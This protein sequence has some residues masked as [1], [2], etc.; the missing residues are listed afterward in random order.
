MAKAFE[1]IRHGI[2]AIVYA[3][4]D[5]SEQL[6]REL[7]RRQV[8]LCLASGVHGM[9]ALGLATEVGKLTERERM[10]VMDWAAEDTDGQVPL[11]LTIYGSSVAEQIG[12]VRHAE[13]VGADW[14]ILQPPACGRYSGSELTD[15]FRRVAETS[16]LPVA[17]QNAPAFL[18]AG[19][20]VD[21]IAKFSE[22]CPNFRLIKAEG[23]VIDI[24]ALIEGTDNSLPVFNGRAG[25]ELIDNLRVGCS[26]FILAPDCIDH[27]VRAYELF[28]AGQEQEA[29]ALYRKIAPSIIFA[30]QG[31]EH[32]ICYGKRIFGARAGIDINDRAPALRPTDVGLESAN[33]LASDLGTFR[34]DDR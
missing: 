9:A 31:I 33:R 3:L 34:V 27:A 15:F 1:H 7:M 28:R 26:G 11:A 2:Y 4:F 16:A 30:M 5:A 17:I 19:L 18:G 12:Q 22:G 24:A 10:T 6:D 13:A 32:L 14:L 25:L 21:E 8:N 23:S 29:E 20:S